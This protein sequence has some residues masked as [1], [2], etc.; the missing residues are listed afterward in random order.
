MAYFYAAKAGPDPDALKLAFKKCGALATAGQHAHIT[1]A[2]PAKGNLRGIIDTVLGDAAVTALLRDN[3]LPLGPITLHI[4]TKQIPVRHLGPVLAAWTK[5][6][7]VTAIDQSGYATDIVY[8]PWLDEELAGFMT[9]FP[10][11]LPLS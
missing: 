1:I 11:A 8:L 3:T 6:D 2:V 5:L 10:Q 7:H 4:A 9:M